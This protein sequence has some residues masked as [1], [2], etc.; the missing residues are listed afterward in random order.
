LKIAFVLKISERKNQIN[1]KR[2]CFQMIQIGAAVLVLLI[3]MPTDSIAQ[4]KSSGGAARPSAKPA[5]K[6]AATKP[7]ARPS[8]TQQSTKPSSAQ[9]PSNV[10]KPSAQ[11]GQNDRDRDLNRGNNAGGRGGGKGTNISNNKV[12]VDKSR[13]DVNINVDNSKDVRVRNTRNT[14]VRHNH[15]NRPYGR[16][17]HVYG[18]YRYRCYH[19]YYYHPYRP[20]IWGPVWHPWGFFITT[21]AATAIIVSFADADLPKQVGPQEFYVLNTN[22][23]AEAPYVRSGP[24]MNYFEPFAETSSKGMQDGEYYYDQGVFYLKEKGGYTVVAA[25]VD[26]VI[27]TLP[28]GYETVVVD[29]ESKTTNYYWGGTFYEKTT[30]GYKVVPPTA[31]TVVQNVSEGGEEVKMGE[32]TYVKFGETYFQPVQVNGKNMYEVADV[33]EDN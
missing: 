10:Q 11:G 14:T 25:P 29:E 24:S 7:A 15:Y 26:A 4:R 31:G 8:A 19:P 22:T 13:G 9:R 30:K 1:M 33:E 5:A 27:K 23:Y 3:T 6:P 2:K 12:N 32:V 18:G 17:P 16:P 20:F 21:L 28:E